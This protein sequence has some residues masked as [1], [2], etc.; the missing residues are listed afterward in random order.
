MIKNYFKVAFRKI[1]RYKA[2]AAIN[3]SGLAIGIAA[4][5]LLFT[6]VKYE[7]SYNSFQSNFKSIYRVVANTEYPDGMDYSAGLPFPAL[8][9]LRATFPGYR[10]G[11]LFASN[12]SQ[13]TIIGDNPSNTA[14][15]KKFIEEKGFLFCDPEYFEVFK[16]NWLVGSPAILSK[17]NTTVLTKSM[18]EKYF[19]DWHLAVGKSLILDNA[20]TVKVEGILQDMPVNT[21][22]AL[23]IVTSFETIKANR[24]LYGY[25]TDWGNFTSNFQVFMLL[26]PKRP[27]SQG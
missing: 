5:L 3:I 12:G 19:G 8:D 2:Y 18:A 10:T 25:T 17:P 23:N 11:A 7:L 27:V 20:V 15:S 1:S 22:F 14:D 4:C 21:D 24:K 26:P 6:V 13:V 9:A 16:F